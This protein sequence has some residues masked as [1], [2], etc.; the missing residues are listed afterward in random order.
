MNRDRKLL[1]IQDLAIIT[2]RDHM[3]RNLNCKIAVHY[4]TELPP[5]ISDII[6]PQPRHILQKM[7]M[8][9]EILLP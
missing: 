1:F 3:G 8:G 9:T 2:A 4:G 5:I 6:R 7:H